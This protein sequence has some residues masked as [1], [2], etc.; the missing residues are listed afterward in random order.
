MV[1]NRCGHVKLHTEDKKITVFNKQDGIENLLSDAMAVDGNTVSFGSRGVIYNIDPGKITKNGAAPDVLITGLR[2]FDKDYD[3]NASATVQLDYNQNYFTFDYLAL[4]YTQSHLNK[5]AYKMVGLDK[6]WNYVGSR[7]Y[8]SYANLD[9]GSYT[10]LVKACNNDGVWNNKPAKFTL[11]ILPPFW[12]RWWFFL[13]AFAITTGAV[14]SLYVYNIKQLKIRLLMR[15]KIARDLHDDIGSTLSGINIFSNIALQKLGFE[16]P[17]RELVEKISDKSQ[18]SLEALSDIVWSI[19]T[20]ND[21]MDD[22]VM[23]ANEYLS[24]LDAQGI[25]YD[26][27]ISPEAGQVKLGMVIRRELYM[28]FKEAVCNAL[29]YAGCSFIKICLSRQKDTFTLLVNDNGKG[30]DT[31][32]ASSGN[33]LYN[34][35]QRAQKMNGT[36]SIDSAVGKGTTVTLKFNITHFR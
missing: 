19:D 26:F 32:A 3:I 21:D 11:I 30:F 25:G 14:Y 28:V 6:K 17:A 35:K 22:F 12:H 7:R 33:G 20:R 5:Y 4:N 24:V 34:M 29:K 36:L 15:D 27:S 16:Q 10:F 9:E 31:A 1:F 18:K 2:V 13:L 8:V 23:K